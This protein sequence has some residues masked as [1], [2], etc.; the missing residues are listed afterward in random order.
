M[1]F[2]QVNVAFDGEPMTIN[3]DH[4]FT[5]KAAY[6]GG[7]ELTMSGNGG[8]Y[9]ITIKE[10]YTLISKLLTTIGERSRSGEL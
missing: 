4:I 10:D 3:T 5:A 9:G 7:T 6:D 2:I 1:A 8:G